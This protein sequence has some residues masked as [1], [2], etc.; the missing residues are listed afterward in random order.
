M[1]NKNFNQLIIRCINI[2]YKL[3]YPTYPIKNI[4]LIYPWPI[5]VYDT[6]KQKCMLK[7]DVLQNFFNN[8]FCILVPSIAREF[9]SEIT[10]HTLGMEVLFLQ[11]S[12]LFSSQKMRLR[13]KYQAFF[14]ICSHIYCTSRHNSKAY[15]YALLLSNL[16][17]NFLR[18][19]N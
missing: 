19:Y 8:D 14:N 2:K 7:H 16:I 10:G 17:R 9:Q 6:L 18:E 1:L 12:L 15:H 3:V 11:P 4:C 13:C 5:I